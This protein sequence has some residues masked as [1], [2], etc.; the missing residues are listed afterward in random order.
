[1]LGD[2]FSYER[3][4]HIHNTIFDSNTEEA[5]NIY[6]NAYVKMTDVEVVK[7]VSNIGSQ[8][9]Q[10]VGALQL[11]CIDDMLDVTLSNVHITNNNM[12]GLLLKGCPVIFADKS[13][14]IS[15][16][17]SPGNGVGMH[18]D[19]RTILHSSV[20]VYF[21]N[22]TATQYDGAIYST[23]NL[24]L[25][26]VYEV[27]IDCSFYKFDVTFLGNL[28]AIAGNDIYGGYYYYWH[29]YL[30][31]FIDVYIAILILFLNIIIVYQKNCHQYHQHH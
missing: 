21:I 13:S 3:S 28:S 18:V 10:Y 19:D 16:N 24:V 6:T 14:V 30:P 8:L 29:H 31:H 25:I 23:A 22:N 9:V 7:T 27:N 11:I 5:L 26:S 17:K 15:N 4:L 20:P 12:T 1:M 2:G